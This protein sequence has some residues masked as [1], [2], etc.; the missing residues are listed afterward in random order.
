MNIQII[1]AVLAT[2]EDQFNQEISAFAKSESLK[3]GWVHIDFMDSEF[4]QNPSIGA[5]LIGKFKIP[6]DKEA[7]LML[8]NPRVVVDELKKAEFGRLVVH[9]ESDDVESVIQY[10]KQQG[11][12]VGLGIQMDTPLENIEAYIKQIDLLLILAV[13]PGYQG[14]QF[15]ANGLERI[16]KVKKLRDELGLKFRIEVDG[17]V[18]KENARQLIEAGADNLVVGSHLLKGDIEENLEGFWETLNI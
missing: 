16:K 7:H 13:K 6:F 4:T 1:P 18:S 9:V 3:H 12:D 11:L 2:T 10:I 5:E 8:K 17:G 15:D 14:Q